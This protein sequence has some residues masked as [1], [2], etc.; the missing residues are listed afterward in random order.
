MKARPTVLYFDHTAALGGGEIALLHLVEALDRGR[1]EPIVVLASDGPLRA[2][3]ERVEVETH[4]LPL[5]VDVVQTRKGSLGSGSLL[6]VGLI[7]RALLYV[8]RLVRFIR[9][10]RIDLVHTNSLKADLIGGLAARLAGVPVVWHVR[11]RIDK[12]YLPAVV[13]TLFRRL[14]RIVPHG[15]I[16][17]S[18]ATLGTLRLPTGA[19]AH[20]VASGVVSNGVAPA[21][22]TAAR[23]R[24]KEPLIGIVGRISPWKGQHIFL[25]AAAT[26]RERFPRAR[27]QIIGSALFDEAEYE[28]DLRALTVDLGLT[29]AVEFTGFRPDVDEMIARLDILIHAST[30]GEPFGQVVAEGMIAGKP[31]IAT[32]GGG[33][34]E[35]IEDGV[36][37]MLVPMDDAPALAAAII[38]LNDNPA[39]AQEIAKAGYRRIVDHFMIS[40]TAGKVQKL[41]DELLGNATEHRA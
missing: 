5:S 12:D 28:Q 7:V 18:Q 36:S 3:L 29:E 15:V 13:V 39:K 40:H 30:T 35:I 25:R 21:I 38:W 10:R 31:V 1:F 6:K 27:F 22:D 33:V 8:V 23:L 41:Y 9:K 26:V 11:D 16:A 2:E 19:N 37:G 32:N 4:L 17:N 20:V 24:F 34:P 14:V